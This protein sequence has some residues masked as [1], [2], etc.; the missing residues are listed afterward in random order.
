MSILFLVVAPKFLILCNF[1][2][3]A[4][5]IFLKKVRFEGDLKKQNRDMKNQP[6]SGWK[7]PGLQVLKGRKKP[8]LAYWYSLLYE[9]KNEILMIVFAP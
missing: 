2:D 3:T 8:T 1:S 9:K 4:M 5:I 6:R 7:N